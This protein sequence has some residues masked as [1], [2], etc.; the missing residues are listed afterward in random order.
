MSFLS[1]LPSRGMVLLALALSSG[2]ISGGA[3]AQPAQGKAAAPA[4]AAPASVPAEPGLTTA[5]FADWVLRC[6]RL[7]DGEKTTRLCEVAQAVQIQG[8]AAPVAQVAIGRVPGEDGLHVTAV[9]PVNASFASGVR[10]AGE[11]KDGK[12]GGALDMA[13]RRCLPGACAAEGPAKDDVLKRWRGPIEASR[14]TFKDAAGREVA[15]PISLRG[16]SQA[17]DALAKERS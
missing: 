11:D 4:Q 3:A 6:Q 13:W 17:L 16:L 14:L 9:L 1:S 15:V 2:P 5:T 10:L 8:Q 12:D 7:V